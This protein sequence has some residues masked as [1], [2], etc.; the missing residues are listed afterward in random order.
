VAGQSPSTGRG[1]WDTRF[2]KKLPLVREVVR[3]CV[4]YLSLEVF[5]PVCAWDT[6]CDTVGGDR[7][8]CQGFSRCVEEFSEKGRVLA[9]SRL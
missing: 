8:L 3:S 6:V 9:Q 4:L 2:W 1:R 5:R 7:D